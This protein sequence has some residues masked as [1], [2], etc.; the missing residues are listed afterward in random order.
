[1]NAPS[2]P[3]ET[4]A[5]IEKALVQLKEVHGVEVVF[6]TD[7]LVRISGWPVHFQVRGDQ[8]FCFWKG[9]SN[10][11]RPEFD[12]GNCLHL[13]PVYHPI[14]AGAKA[15]CAVNGY[16]GALIGQKNGRV[17]SLD[18]PIQAAVSQANYAWLRMKHPFK[19][20]GDSFTAF[21]PPK[22]QLSDQDQAGLFGLLVAALNLDNSFVDIGGG[23][24]PPL[25]YPSRVLEEKKIDSPYPGKR[26]DFP[27]RGSEHSCVWEYLVLKREGV[28][29]ESFVPTWFLQ[30]GWLDIYEGYIPEELLS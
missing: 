29:E 4:A 17:N 26:P 19:A 8:T 22:H 21:W 12:L 2:L 24:Q 6:T 23:F 7:P 11:N 30:E 3:A 15:I 18:C 27:A 14:V 16:T 9:V 10:P 5:M 25:D 28:L 13:I 1:V 20:E